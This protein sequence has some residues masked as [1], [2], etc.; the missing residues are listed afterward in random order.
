MK[1]QT[2]K[3]LTVLLLSLIAFGCS[4]LPQPKSDSNILGINL[5]TS[6]TEAHKRLNELGKLDREESKQQEI[7]TLN[8]DPHYSHLI[9]A[10]DKENQSVR[11]ITAIA[12]EN[13]TPVQ[14]RDIID[15]EKA[16]QT[17]SANNYKYVQEIEGNL[18]TSGYLKIA[19]GKDIN[20]LT[21]FSLKKLNSSEEEDEEEEE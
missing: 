1:T 12:R 13:G 16:K 3:I 18:T 19:S 8:N 4:Y 17:G 2:L 20:N 5:G 14:Y 21:Y 9:L 7:W 15:T 10:F 6:K 11:Y